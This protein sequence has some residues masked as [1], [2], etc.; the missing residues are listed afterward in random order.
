MFNYLLGKGAKIDNQN[1]PLLAAVSNGQKDMVI[2]LSQNHKKDIHWDSLTRGHQSSL[3]IMAIEKEPDLELFKILV[4]TGSSIYSGD[5]QD[6]PPIHSFVKNWNG[7]HHKAIFE[8]MLSLDSHII[9][10]GDLHQKTCIYHAITP[11]VTLDDV[12]YFVDKGATINHDA[13]LSVLPIFMAA[14]YLNI[15]VV[16]YLIEQGT[17]LSEQ[18]TNVIFSVVSG[19]DGKINDNGKYLIKKFISLGVDINARGYYS[20]E[21]P[22]FLCNDLESIKFM[23]EN[24]AN[25]LLKDVDNRTIL[26]YHNDL[27][28]IDHNV[29]DYLLN[30][31]IDIN[32]KD[33]TEGNTSLHM[34]A[35]VYHLNQQVFDI[36][37]Y[38]I[39]KGAD[40]MLL[41]NRG[42]TL[43]DLLSSEDITFAPNESKADIE[44]YLRQEM[45]KRR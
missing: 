7:D 6:A 45:N 44:D 2:Y 36:I 42:K 43:L 22:L 29:I 23:V 17:I 19:S 5:Y 8:Y 41:D 4:E 38:L 40:P 30:V 20:Q 9:N 34:M 39:E 24:G 33:K 1:S 18:H 16:D 21:T 3:H 31:G 14:M 28:T 37:K 27:H 35:F 15:P 11:E 12:K 32:N 25:P 13:P 10:R 26:Q